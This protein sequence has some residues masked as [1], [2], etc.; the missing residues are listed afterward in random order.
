MW[1]LLYSKSTKENS[2][3]KGLKLLNGD[4]IQ[5]KAFVISVFMYIN[6]MLFSV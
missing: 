4:L 3:W 1:K 6:L 5:Y 2:A